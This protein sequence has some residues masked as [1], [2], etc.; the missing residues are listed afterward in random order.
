M[1]STKNNNIL[2]YLVDCYLKAKYFF[3]LNHASFFFALVVEMECLL[4]SLK[5]L[6]VDIAKKHYV[7]YQAV[8][9]KDPHF[10]GLFKPDTIEKTCKICHVKFD[11][12]RLKKK[13]YFFVSLW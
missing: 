10:L 13:A 6:K 9:E 4:C 2:E 3:L 8:N 11:T 5:F 1:M 12:C 7:D